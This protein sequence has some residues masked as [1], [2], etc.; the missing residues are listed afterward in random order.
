MFFNSLPDYEGPF[1]VGFLDVE[2][3]SK[4]LDHGVLM[5]IYYPSRDVIHE[6]A[7]SNWLPHS[8]SYSKGYGHFLKY[9]FAAVALFLYPALSLAKK[10]ALPNLALAET[11]KPLPLAIF[12]H[13]LGGMR[14]T[15]SQICGNLAS[16]GVVVCA[17]E[18]ADGSAAFTSRL[19][20][21]IE[22]PH[23]HPHIDNLDEGETV[24]EGL[25]KFRTK[26]VNQRRDEIIEA[27]Q[28]LKEINNAN[29]ESLLSIDDQ[30]KMVLA[31]FHKK[32]DFKA[33]ALIGHSFGGATAIK[34]LDSVSDIKFKCAVLLDPWMYSVQDCKIDNIPVLNLQ[35]A[36]FHWKDNLN[37]MKNLMNDA[38]WHPDG[39]FGH[40]RD[41][42]HQDA[43]DLGL[44]FPYLMGKLKQSGPM[45]SQ[46][47]HLIQ[48]KLIR[49]FMKKHIELSLESKTNP[50]PSMDIH[51][52]F[53]NDSWIE[54]EK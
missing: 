43:S 24:D 34:V 15:Y 41:S 42:S 33:I 14:T 7:K 23:Q 21:T 8:W 48:E 30:H 5:R 1:N 18:H 20:G 26:Q 6:S 36:N 53:G 27:V 31:K 50:L 29:F 45:P 39:V 10:R 9:P 40:I 38:S 13:G 51:C 2:A 44:L 52:R 4:K 16:R 28:I 12:S 46:E 37:S 25:L 3:S 11:D 17:I 35:S 32:I 47:F 49:E 22:I 54:L 19:N